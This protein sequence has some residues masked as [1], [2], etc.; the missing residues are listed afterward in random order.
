MLATVHLMDAADLHLRQ[1]LGVRPGESDPAGML[2]GVLLLL[3]VIAPMAALALVW[4]L[5]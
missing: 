2:C 4:W 1:D 5:A 3:V